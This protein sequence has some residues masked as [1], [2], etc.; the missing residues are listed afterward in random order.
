MLW[1]KITAKFL[2]F[3]Q[4]IFKIEREFDYTV[5]HSCLLVLANFRIFEG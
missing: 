5:K 3:K 2:L 4:L 1:V